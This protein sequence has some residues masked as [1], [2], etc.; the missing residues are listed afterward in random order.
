MDLAN[1]NQI[2][3]VFMEA[4]QNILQFG[5]NSSLHV[6]DTVGNIKSFAQV[7]SEEKIFLQS[8]SS[9]NFGVSTDFSTKESAAYTDFNHLSLWSMMRYMMSNQLASKKLSD[10]ASDL[11][12]NNKQQ[13]TD[14][15][16]TLTRQ[17]GAEIQALISIPATVYTVDPS[18]AAPKDGSAAKPNLAVVGT[19]I[20]SFINGSSFE[21]H[22][23]GVLD[24]FVQKAK[25][26]NAAEAY[27][28]ISV[29]SNS[30][31]SVVRTMYF[32]KM[33]YDKAYLVKAKTDKTFD[34]IIN[35]YLS[36]LWNLFLSRYRGAAQ[37]MQTSAAQEM[38]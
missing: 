15:I 14:Y 5:A 17:A 38:G 22:L 28:G 30:M 13:Q 23:V 2:R 27:A 3:A 20:E 26:G 29:L 10:I 1:L 35:L 36:N 12:P 18:P 33:E 7:I 31:T 16:E 37:A 34:S 6:G 9:G 25:A 8:A 21:S 11:H 32:A 4:T 24:S 19:N